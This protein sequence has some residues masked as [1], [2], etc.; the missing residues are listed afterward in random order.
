MP[1][2]RGGLQASRLPVSRLS[3]LEIAG[4]ETAG[5]KTAGLET[6]SFETPTFE[7]AS[8]ETASV[9]GPAHNCSRSVL[10]KGMM[11]VTAYRYQDCQSRDSQS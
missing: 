11:H 2:A 6:T 5:L 4:L 10:H 7:T 9:Y 1:D 8:L 3:A